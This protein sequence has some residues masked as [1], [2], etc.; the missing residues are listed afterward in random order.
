MLVPVTPN[1]LQKWCM[2]KKFL[3]EIIMH[4]WKTAH[5]ANYCLDR[6][7]SKTN[8]IFHHLQCHATAQAVRYQ[9]LTQ[10]QVQSQASLYG[11]YSRTSGTVTVFS[12]HFSSPN[13]IPCI[14]ISFIYHKQYIKPL[15][16]SSFYITPPI[17]SPSPLSISEITGNL[18]TVVILRCCTRTVHT[19]IQ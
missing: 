1:S 6:N 18:Q 9:P 17:P 5:T 12:Q 2:S 10:L 19:A 15:Q 16:P 8:M 3:N 11:I 14:R 7:Q 13:T 4:T